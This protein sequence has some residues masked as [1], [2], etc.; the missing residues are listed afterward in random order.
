MSR[1]RSPHATAITRGADLIEGSQR[2]PNPDLA[3]STPQTSIERLTQ[4]FQQDDGG[5]PASF[6][7]DTVLYLAYGSNLSEETFRGRRAIRPLSEINVS[8][9]TMRLTLGLAGIPYMEPCFANVDFRK[10][11]EKPK[12]PDT[13][14]LPPFASPAYAQGEWD[15]GLMGVVYEV[16]KE[17]YSQ[18]IRTEGGG[19]G[20]KQIVVPCIPLPPQAAIPEKPPIPELP[21]PVLA[22][23][24]YCPY[25]PQG[26]PDQPD[27]R[28]FWRKLFARPGR[29]D[30][31]YAQASARYLKLITDGAREHN[32][33]DA[34]QEYL[35]SLQPYTITSPRQKIGRILLIGL[36]GPLVLGAMGISR[37]LA[38]KDGKYPPVM[39]AV[40][41]LLFNLVWVAHD[42]V[43][44]PIFG[45]GER[46]ED[47]RGDR[48]R[49]L[50]FGS[51]VKDEEKRALMKEEDEASAI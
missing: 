15:G 12:L 23:T 30:P 13:P 48:R 44:K 36:A 24:L 22:R 16:T 17:D 47:K 29:P 40:M 37:L 35:Q 41:N 4:N 46:T 51:P 45:D 19:S 11:P 3:T 6:D 2:P 42:W 43:L 21:K 1:N 10:L 9:P 49:R 38:D 25:V 27:E 5:E 31:D 33:P 7:S 14:H 26:N 39:G 34:Y 18:I 28:S 20:Y 50:S 8:V 32:L